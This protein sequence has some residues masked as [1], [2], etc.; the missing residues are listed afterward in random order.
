MRVCNATTESISSITACISSSNVSEIP[1]NNLEPA[2]EES[3]DEE[4]ST[5]EDASSGSPVCSATFV[6]RKPSTSRQAYYSHPLEAP[7]A[8]SCITLRRAGTKSTG[9]TYCTPLALRP[10]LSKGREIPVT[11]DVLII[12][13]P[14]GPQSKRLLTRLG[15]RRV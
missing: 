5:T 2:L 15:E 10:F 4:G 1:S 3:S 9:A 7:E 6:V 13:F 14:H 11:F 8:V 12:P